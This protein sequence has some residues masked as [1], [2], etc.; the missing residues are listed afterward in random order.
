M[1]LRKGR[2][3]LKTKELQK[4][5]RLVGASIA[6]IDMSMQLCM[7]RRED[8]VVMRRDVSKLRGCPRY[9]AVDPVANELV[10]HP[11]A[12]QDYAVLQRWQLDYEVS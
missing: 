5:A 8:M 1:L 3:S 9:M 11:A 7:I 12:D 6:T 2:S 10:F 4:G